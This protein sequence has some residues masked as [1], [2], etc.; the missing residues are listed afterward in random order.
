MG[1]VEQSPASGTR[2][3]SG[4]TV[5]E[6]K[7]TSPTRSQRSDYSDAPEE[8]QPRSRHRR[9]RR[10]KSGGKHRKSSRTAEASVDE[11]PPSGQPRYGHLEEAAVYENDQ[12]G[13]K[14]MEQE[15]RRRAR[16]DRRGGEDREERSSRRGAIDATEPVYMPRSKYYADP[17][18]EVDSSSRSR[19]NHR[20]SRHRHHRRRHHR[21][22][23]HHKSSTREVDEASIYV[24]PKTP[25]QVIKC[26]KPNEFCIYYQLPDKRASIP[27]KLRLFLAY[28]SSQ[29]KEVFHF[30]IVCGKNAR[31]GED[32]WSLRYTDSAT[33]PTLQALI[34]YHKIYSYMDPNTG[35]IDTFPVWK[36]AIIN[37]DSYNE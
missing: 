21:R 28:M 26:L 23:G 20:Q 6:S 16:R 10:H 35:K 29:N 24:G 19:G 17:D 34:K 8:S 25:S 13:L 27:Y 5:D 4:E 30:P 14:A 33:F 22:H 15:R 31:T 12:G 36:G 37:D 7:T 2:T 32:V 9:D 1:R 3:G 18:E 11:P